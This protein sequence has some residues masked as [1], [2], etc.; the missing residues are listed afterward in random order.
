MFLKITNQNSMFNFNS[1]NKT[2]T[3]DIQIRLKIVIL[4][5]N[6]FGKEQN[7]FAWFILSFKC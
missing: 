6:I 4:I 2:M 3:Q 7:W 1:K 5:F